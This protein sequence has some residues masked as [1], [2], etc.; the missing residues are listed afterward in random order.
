MREHVRQKIDEAVYRIYLEIDSVRFPL[1]PLGA[2]ALFPDCRHMTYEALSA[3][4]G[5]SHDEII[6]ACESYDGCTK[7]EPSTGRYLILVN[8]SKRNIASEDRIRW[9]TAH[10]LGHIVCGHFEELSGA[11]SGKVQSSDICSSEMEEEAD[12]FAASLLAPLPV[13]CKIGV[14]DV[15]DIK[16]GFGLSQVAAEHR[17]AEFNRYLRN[18]DTSVYAQ[19]PNLWKLFRERGIQSLIPY[20]FFRKPKMPNGKPVDIPYP[21]MDF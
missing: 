9:T 12:A 1:D 17:W 10:E 18:A 2:I 3:L 21:D 13:L 6:K 19:Q 7:F 15:R 11:H 16:K 8:N 14:R 20:H 5:K 4:S